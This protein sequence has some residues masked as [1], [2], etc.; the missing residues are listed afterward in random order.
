MRTMRIPALALCT[1]MFP[2]LAA[3]SPT[4][5]GG[6]SIDDGGTYDANQFSGASVSLLSGTLNISPGANLLTVYSW[7]TPGGGPIT[8]TGG[9]VRDIN[10][11]L[12]GI[13]ISGG[14]IGLGG[15]SPGYGGLEVEGQAVI[16]GGTF[17][18]A[19][20]NSY[21]ASGSAVVGNAGTNVGPGNTQTPFMSTLKISGGTFI[22][23][24]YID[25]FNPLDPRVTFSGY[26]LVSEGN[27]TV[28][29]GKFLS[30][31]LINGF[32]GGE[33]DF[34][35]KNLK[36]Q[37]GI[38][39][40]LLQNG[41]PINVQVWAQ[42]ANAIVNSTGTEVSFVSTVT[43]PPASSLQTA[44][45]W[46]QVPEPNSVWIF[47]VLALLGLSRRYAGRSRPTVL[48]CNRLDGH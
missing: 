41:D 45:P 25:G 33:T 30:E 1:L 29:G 14:Q 23:G 6:W 21:F 44:Q 8:M 12:Y 9:Q 26:S 19:S 16:T 28:T 34:I 37:S 47:G 42:S 40:G 43:P 35:G 4:Y 18:G 15:T 17:T 13:T 3:A 38:L 48:G 10:A 27:T 7:F 39:S 2:T 32:M 24:S 5:Q 20:G 36:F 31:I 22:G 46:T 11:G